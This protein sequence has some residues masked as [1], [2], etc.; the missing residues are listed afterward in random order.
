MSCIGN[1]RMM[2]VSI[3]MDH[4]CPKNY[5]IFANQSCNTN[6]DYKITETCNKYIMNRTKNRFNVKWENVLERN[7][8]FS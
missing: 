5:G 1:C 8:Y 2:Y 6:L 7:G 3:G 4:L